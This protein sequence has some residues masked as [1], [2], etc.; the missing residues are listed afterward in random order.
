MQKFYDYLHGGLPLC[1]NV[2]YISILVSQWLLFLFICKLL[3]K[4][5]KRAVKYVKS[6]LE[7]NKAISENLWTI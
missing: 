1:N 6:K 5:I 2:D 4:S 3:F 7:S